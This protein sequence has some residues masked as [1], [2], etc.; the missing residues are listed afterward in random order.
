MTA[1]LAKYLA[2]PTWSR[3]VAITKYNRKHPFAALML[4]PLEQGLLADAIAV[5]QG[6]GILD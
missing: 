1:L 6:K 3:A 4:S 5:A 2:Q